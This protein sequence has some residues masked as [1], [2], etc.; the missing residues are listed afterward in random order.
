MVSKARLRFSASAR[1]GDDGQLSKRQIEID[2]LE[3]VLART[4]NLDA[5]ALRRRGDAFFFSDLRTHRRL[6]V[7]RDAVRKFFG[8]IIW[9][10]RPL[11][12]RGIA[13]PPTQSEESSARV[14]RLECARR[15]CSRCFSNSVWHDAAE[16]LEEFC[17]IGQLLFAIPRD[18]HSR[19]S[20]I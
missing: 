13:A 16:R 8:E 7:M 12:R 1:A 10:I 2:A 15:G 14:M 11:P 18:R 4:A 6:S 17:V 20:R 19:S 3:V 9:A 5:T